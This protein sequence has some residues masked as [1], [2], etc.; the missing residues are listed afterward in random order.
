MNIEEIRKYCISKPG[1]SESFPFDEDTLVFKVGGKM[2]CLISL[3]ESNNINVKCDPERALTLREA[4]EFI[5]PGYHM[6]KNHWNT[7]H[8]VTGV[9]KSF[10][11][12]MIDHSYG[13]VYNSLPR[14]IKQEI[15]DQIKL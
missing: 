1:T 10:Y 5:K 8:I 2:F 12:E 11:Q 7:V 3:S 14:K 9:N 4:H 15:L 6:N 13:L